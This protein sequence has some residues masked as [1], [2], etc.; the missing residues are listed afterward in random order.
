[1]TLKLEPWD[2]KNYIQELQDNLSGYDPFPRT[3]ADFP[4]LE[5]NVKWEQEME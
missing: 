4:G 3:F 2:F 1:M 5:Q